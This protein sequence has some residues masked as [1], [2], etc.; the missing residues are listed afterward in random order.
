MTDPKS[1]RRLP[2]LNDDPPST[3]KT[4][5]RGFLGGL[6]AAAASA[7]AAVATGGC[8]TVDWDEFFQRHYKEMTPEEKAE[9]CATRR[10]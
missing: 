3:G 1:P 9:S 5:R 2:V 6:G 4:G 10:G 8:A 7:S